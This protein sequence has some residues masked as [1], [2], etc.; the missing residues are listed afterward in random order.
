MTKFNFY[1]VG[2]TVVVTASPRDNERQQKLGAK[3]VVDYR[4]ADVIDKLRQLGPYKYLFTASGDA[5]SQTALA[6]LLQP[7]GGKFASV[8]PNTAELPSNVE[9][10]YRAFSQAAQEEQYSDWRN[11]WY[12]EYLPEVLSKGLVEPVR[13]T[14]VEG[15]LPA[16]QRAS[17]DAFNGKV[18]G[19]LVVNPQE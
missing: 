3:H 6:T 7:T 16:L 10:V 5:A 15:G 14:K 19:K 18:K 9:M 2:H 17:E 12:R 8:L 13:F 11:W 1:Q 4:A